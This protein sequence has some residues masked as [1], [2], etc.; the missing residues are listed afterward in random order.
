MG[1]YERFAR[2]FTQIRAPTSGLK[3]KK[4]TPLIDSGLYRSSVSIRTSSVARQRS[5]MPLR[6]T[7]RGDFLGSK[8]FGNEGVYLLFP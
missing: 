6:V 8:H 1:N 2:S 5:K 7:D 4:S 3:L